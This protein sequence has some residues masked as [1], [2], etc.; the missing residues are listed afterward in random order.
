MSVLR[1]EVR[2]L[3]G[4]VPVGVGPA[5]N[6]AVVTVGQGL[7]GAA[8]A[9]NWAGIADKP[10]TYPA[11]P[12]G[13]KLVDVQ[14]LQAVLD[15]QS[16]AIAAAVDTAAADATAKADRAQADAIAAA[17][18]DAG[19]KASLGQAEAIAAAAL[20]ATTKAS[21]AIGTASADATAKANAA[22]AAAIAAAALDATAKA[23]AAQAASTP[24]AHAGSVGAAHGNAT[25]SIPGFMS[26]ADKA[27][28]DGVAEN[29]NAYTHPASH[30]ATIITQDAGNRFVTDAEKVAWNAKQA[31]LGF[32]PENTANKGV[33]SGYA[34][35]DAGGKVPS[36]QLPSFVDDVIEVGSFAALPA[37]GESGKIYVTPDNN[38]TYR[39]GGTA[40]AEISAS[41]GSTDAVPEGVS[42]LY[43]T[44]ARVRDA[45]LTG[46]STAS[47]AVVTAA[48]SVLTAL[49]KIQAQII[50][51]VGN[52]ANPHSVTKTQV[53]LGNADNTSDADKP[54]STATAS[55]LATKET[56]TNKGIPSGYAG[57]DAGGK[58]PAAQLPSF[59]DDVIEVASFAALPVTGESGK[60]YI[61]LGDGKTWRWG[62]TAYAEISASPGSTDAVP[63]GMSNLYHTA[64]RVRDAV[65]AGL[66]T[67]S[68]A[69]VTAAD[70][71]LA[72]FGKLQAQITGHVG[73]TTNP[74]SVTKAQVGLGNVDNTSDANKPISTAQQAAFDLKLNAAN[75]SYTGTLTGGTGVVNLGSGQ[76]VKDASG[77]VGVGTASP[78]SKVDVV[79]GQIEAGNGAIRGVISYSSRVEIGALSNHDLGF[80]ANGESKAVLTT[81]GNL[82]IGTASPTGR[83]TVEGALG[84]A[85][86]NALTLRNSLDGGVGIYFD[87]AVSNNLASI[88]AHVTSAGSGTDDGILAF[89]TATDGVNIERMRIDSSGNLGIGTASPTA[90]LEV[91]TATYN[92]L[93]LHLG[94]GV[95]SAGIDFRNRLTAI[96][97]SGTTATI[98]W[99]DTPFPAG[100]LLLAARPG[101]GSVVLSASGGQDVVLTP[102]GNFGL[103]VTPSAWVGRALDIGGSHSPIV[104]SFASVGNTQNLAS[105][106]Y[107]DGVWRYRY[108]YNAQLY[109]IGDGNH[110]W[111]TAPNGAAGNPISFTR[112]M[113]LD[114]SG[115]LLVGTAQS[116]TTVLSGSGSG[117]TVAGAAPN[118]SVWA[119]GNPSWSAYFGQVASNTYIANA[120]D[121]FLSLG[122]NNTERARIDPSGSL[123][124]GTAVGAMHTLQK[125]N[126]GDYAAKVANT[127]AASPY[128]LAVNLASVTGG[129]GAVFI[130]C[131]DDATRFMVLGSG[132]V[133]NV[134]NS[135]GAISDAKLK[136]NIT[137]V[138]PKL[139]KLMQVRIVNYTLKS[140][141]GKLKQIGVIAQEL[142]QVMP[143]LV[144]E[145]PDFEEVTRTREVDVPAVD[146]ALD[147]DGNEV[148]P[149]VAA[150]TRTE[151]YTERV[152]TGATTKAVKYSVFV[153]IL[154]KALQE[155]YEAVQLMQQQLDA[156]NTAMQ[157]LAERV[158]ALE[159]RA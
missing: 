86:L 80:I 3:S 147:A 51:H 2:L 40:Y 89:A 102:A 49:G 152:A 87:N 143:G 124:V 134:N 146:A 75:P 29:A 110:T 101:I 56:T 39:W 136:E 6:I 22:Q 9:T 25:T 104:G 155:G 84:V 159:A 7:R 63:E 30:P 149:A 96:P 126:A 50:G 46:L 23:G 13:H 74:H 71:V 27:K 148:T 90:K 62:G 85:T 21:A 88:E 94:E 11:Q 18:L 140:D 97:T 58:V 57:L 142:E 154:I 121:G 60:I 34:S 118:L 112:A 100:G 5:K 53:G 52:I 127:S 92:A 16:G 93:A 144:E 73:S 67:A 4:S 128:G 129:A 79:G 111:Y 32:T 82:G 72:A 47:S 117:I 38:K 41:P 83:L 76:F 153:P 131:N 103:G 12:H 107:Y 98:G 123:L 157:L 132:N 138:S 150:T 130:A 15:E 135:Y 28:L 156:Q 106:A 114:A 81:T 19:A 99:L 36:A 37:I 64:A 137:D 133:Q 109:S 151:T 59:V 26:A 66:S 125:A 14:G 122:T 70:S 33:P 10:D 35:L 141:P 44:A 42:N 68:S 77:N 17:A 1:T 116:K 91:S 24:A 45:V 113:T 20:D 95:A 54:V 120:A 145:T 139:A 105:N 55:A 119:T 115:N 158:A 8:G 61:T 48:D 69:V 78:R 108:A 43:H 31:A 65:L